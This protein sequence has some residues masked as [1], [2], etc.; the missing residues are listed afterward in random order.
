MRSAAQS[1]LNDG[2]YPMVSSIPNELWTDHLRRTLLSYDEPLLRQVSTKLCKPR[3]HW[4]VA[5]LIDRC[6]TNL[7]NA[8][9]LDR[10][11]RDLDA[12]GRLILTLIAHSRQNLWPVG[13]LIETL[14]TLGVADGLGSVQGLLEAGLLYPSLFP[15][16]PE[17]DQN[18][19]RAGRARLKGFDYWLAQSTAPAVLRILPSWSGRSAKCWRGRTSP[20]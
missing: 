9:V 20:N 16:G 6:L 18:Q 17:S 2:P 1:R 14:V 12:P 7:T 5:E 3:N 15:L 19:P 8:A 11:L 10:R 13:N 4:P